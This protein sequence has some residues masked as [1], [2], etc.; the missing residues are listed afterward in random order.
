[1]S[2]LSV[3]KLNETQICASWWWR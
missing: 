1:M 2:I 3:V